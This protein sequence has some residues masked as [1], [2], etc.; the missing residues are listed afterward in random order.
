MVMDVTSTVMRKS[1]VMACFKAISVSFAM[2]A[3]RLK[4]TVVTVI[5]R[6]KSA[7]IMCS[8]LTLVKNVMTGIKTIM[9]GVITNVKYRSVVMA[10]YKVRRHVMMAQIIAM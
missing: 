2:M 5:V 3:I 8:S 7:V 1:V 10:K 6:P 9:M 4:E